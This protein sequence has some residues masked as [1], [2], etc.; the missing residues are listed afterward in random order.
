MHQGEIF[1]NGP[2]IV[3]TCQSLGAL[4]ENVDQLPARVLR[5]IARGHGIRKISA[6]FSKPHIHF[7]LATHACTLDCPP[8]TLV[9]HLLKKDRKFVK[10][11]EKSKG[12]QRAVEPDYVDTNEEDD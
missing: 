8:T 9:F 4:V 10:C 2:K 7:L 12:K 3:V 11:S 6:N 5:V 1:P